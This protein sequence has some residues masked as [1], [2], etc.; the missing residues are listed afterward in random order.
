M[1]LLQASLQSQRGGPCGQWKFLLVLIIREG[2]GGRMDGWRRMDLVI[3]DGFMS[4][5]GL[6]SRAD[7]RMCCGPQE[8]QLG[9]GRVLV[10]LPRL[11]V[12]WAPH[13]TLPYLWLVG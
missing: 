8:Q 11:L 12:C 4:A 7:Q 5:P 1:Q 2:G 3:G 9:S 6:Q 10:V 13:P